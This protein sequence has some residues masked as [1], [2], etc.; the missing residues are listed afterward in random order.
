[1]VPGFS[2]VSL[3]DFAHILFNELRRSRLNERSGAV[4]YSFVMALPPTILFFFSLVPYVPLGDLESSI[5][6]FI[7]LVTPDSDLRNSLRGFIDDFLHKE[8]RGV[9][10]F[11]VL[12]TLYFSSNGIVGLIRSFER[13]HPGFVRRSGIR[14]RWMAIKL[15][16]MLIFVV[17]LTL[18]MLLIQTNVVN[19]Y[20]QRLFPSVAAVKLL[21]LV[22]VLLLILLSIS[23]VYRY[24]P[25]MRNPFPLITP[26]SVF[27]TL[28]IGIATS[29]FFWAV[30]NFLNYNRVYGPIGSVI[31]FMVW[32]WLNTLIILVGY[33]IN[34]SILLGKN[35]LISNKT[36]D[37]SSV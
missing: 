36:S 25:S 14:Q 4:T 26:G 1:M 11:G 29:V 27:A 9:L 5:H 17:I 13:S 16:L 6:Q 28:G 8:Q 7:D 20:L 2:G 3:Y 33:E 22:V 18:A 12:L 32:M 21:S 35:A 24:G 10:S 37:C 23:M 30:N 34:I 15:T 31:A 19:A